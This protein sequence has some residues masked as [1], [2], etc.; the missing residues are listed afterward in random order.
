MVYIKVVAHQVFRATRKDI[1]TLKVALRLLPSVAVKEPAAGSSID[2][3]GFQIMRDECIAH[4]SIINLGS[5]IVTKIIQTIEKAYDSEVEMSFPMHHIHQANL[6]FV[7]IK[8]F[9]FRADNPLEPAANAVYAQVSTSSRLR[10]VVGL[11]SAMMYVVTIELRWT[12]PREDQD[13]HFQPCSYNHD[14]SH[15]SAPLARLESDGKEILPYHSCFR[16]ITNFIE[17][18]PHASFDLLAYEASKVA[19]AA[20][21]AGLR[22]PRITSL[23]IAVSD[24]GPKKPAKG[25]TY[26]IN[27]SWIFNSEWYK[28]LNRAQKEVS[29]NDDSHRVLIALGSNIGDRVGMIEQACAEMASRGLKLLRTS[30]LYETEAMYKTD[31]PPFVNGVCEVSQGPV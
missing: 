13:P 28:R 29:S 12:V 7:S 15:L 26:N 21:E 30:S 16:H 24:L 5:A 4:D 23:R 2:S 11:E 1:A 3:T 27:Q 6:D 25:T 10:L 31:Q 9:T 17:S 14:T 8:F 20:S 18:K 22:P 19:F